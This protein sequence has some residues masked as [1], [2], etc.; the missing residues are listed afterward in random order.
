VDPFI[1]LT[2]HGHDPH[3]EA[4]S[5]LRTRRA[6]VFTVDVFAL[7]FTEFLEDPA[8]PTHGGELDTSLMLHLAPELVRMDLAQ[9]FPLT[10][11]QV[12]RYR[13]RAAGS[14]PAM[15][16][17]SVGRPTLA[18]AEKGARLYKMIHDRIA[19]RVLGGGAGVGGTVTA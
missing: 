17:G 1:I 9:D 12:A 13:R 10:P 3:Q 11:R 19:T 8:G 2:A 14:V 7:D 5:T 16:P 18:S 4:L 15:S 6:R